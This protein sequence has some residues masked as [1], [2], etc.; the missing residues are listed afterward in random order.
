M[1]GLVDRDPHRNTIDRLL[2]DLQQQ[3]RTVRKVL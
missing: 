1:E 2:I 3:L